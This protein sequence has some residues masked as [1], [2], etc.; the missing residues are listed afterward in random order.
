MKK[1]VKDFC[2]KG[3]VA[4]GFGPMVLVV[5]YLILQKVCNIQTLTVNEV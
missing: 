1:L 2:R 5:L 3:I 4:C